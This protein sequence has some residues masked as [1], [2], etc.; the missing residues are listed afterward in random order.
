MFDKIVAWFNGANANPEVDGT[1]GDSLRWLVE[2]LYKF[3][4]ELLNLFG[5]WPIDVK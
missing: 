5:E 4:A 3:V 1:N 2:S